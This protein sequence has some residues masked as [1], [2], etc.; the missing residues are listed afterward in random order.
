MSMFGL[1]FV[2]G[3]R[4]GKWGASLDSLDVG[5]GCIGTYIVSATSTNTRSNA[6]QTFTT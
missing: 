6:M 5:M 2:A 3:G 1:F 4:S